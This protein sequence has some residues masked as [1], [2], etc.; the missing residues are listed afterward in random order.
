[1]EEEELLA[2]KAEERGARREI[3]KRKI[4]EWRDLIVVV[5]EI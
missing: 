2:E 4:Y 5:E 3:R 1:M